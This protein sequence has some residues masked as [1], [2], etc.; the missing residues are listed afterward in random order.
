MLSN[1]QFVIHLNND[2]KSKKR[3]LN[4]GLPQ[5]SVLT[6]LLFNLYISDLLKTA[7]KQFIY[8]DD[9]CIANQDKLLDNCAYTFSSDLQTL[10]KFLIQWRLT[11]SSS[12]TE[13]SAFHLNNKMAD[14]NLEITYRGTRLKHVPHPKYLGVTLDRTLTFKTHLTNVASKIDSR[15]N[16]IQKLTGTDWG[17]DFLTLRTSTFTLV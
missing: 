8:A 9:I 4:N 1:R 11:P 14:Y 7:S 6:P 2:T 15:I 16:I 3:T 10:D 13:T 12:K 17:A 5:G